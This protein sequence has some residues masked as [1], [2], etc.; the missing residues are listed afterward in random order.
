MVIPWQGLGYV[1]GLHAWAQV[2]RTCSQGW[3]SLAVYLGVKSP[4]LSL[5]RLFLLWNGLPARERCEDVRGA[6][7]VII[8]RYLYTTVIR[9]GSRPSFI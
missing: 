7:P 2:R 9:L 4:D 3:H 8:S 1:A 6:T 5:P